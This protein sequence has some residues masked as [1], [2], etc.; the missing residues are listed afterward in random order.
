MYNTYLEESLL[1]ILQMLTFPHLFHHI[2]KQLGCLLEIK[3]KSVFKW[4]M[5]KLQNIII[6]SMSV[7]EPPP[8]PP[9]I[10]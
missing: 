5:Q 10:Q 2:L 7:S 6:Q 4:V 9:L 3:T 1:D 8:T